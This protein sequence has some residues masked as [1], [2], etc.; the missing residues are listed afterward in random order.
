MGTPAATE[1][2]SDS[3][4]TVGTAGIPVDQPIINSVAS[5]AVTE[6]GPLDVIIQVYVKGSRNLTTARSDVLNTANKLFDEYGENGT[7]RVYV[8]NYNGTLGIVN[9]KNYATSKEEAEVLANN[10]PNCT[11]TEP[12][13]FFDC[14]TSLVEN[15][16]KLDSKRPDTDTYHV[17][18]DRSGIDINDSHGKAQS[19][20]ENTIK[21]VFCY[22]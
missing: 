14:V 13:N 19:F 3:A 2:Q 21:K 18:V 6:P 4:N 1:V 10:L 20:I 8:A 12:P 7:L 5:T 17:F 11:T 9:K 16:N 22:K 15:Y